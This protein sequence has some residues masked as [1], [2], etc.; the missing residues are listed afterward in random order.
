[1]GFGTSI[2][3]YCGHGRL[4]LRVPASALFL[5]TYYKSNTEAS[6]VWVHLNEHSLLDLREWYQGP[7]TRPPFSVQYLQAFAFRNGSTLSFSEQN[8]SAIRLI[9]G[10]ACVAGTKLHRGVI[11]R[12]VRPGQD[13]PGGPGHG[14]LCLETL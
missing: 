13:A 1:M 6:G 5:F 7:S 9:I 3:V 11:I 10:R 4:D 14:N 8:H 12:Q 2:S